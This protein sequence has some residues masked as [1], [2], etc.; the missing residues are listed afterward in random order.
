MEQNLEKKPL[1]FAT[2]Y[3]LI[4]II[5]VFFTWFQFDVLPS[6]DDVFLLESQSDF[7]EVGQGSYKGLY[8]WW[9]KLWRMLGLEAIGAAFVS[10]IATSLLAYL[11]LFYLLIRL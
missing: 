8:V 5:Y 10:Q 9:I 6:S 11:S 3:L 7:W 2:Q 4:P 1:V